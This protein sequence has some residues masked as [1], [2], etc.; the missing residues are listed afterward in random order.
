MSVQRECILIVLVAGIGDL[1]LASKGIRAIRNGYPEAEIHLLTS[2]DAAPLA[3][4]Y[5]YIDRV[6]PFPIRE[7]RGDRAHALAVLGLIRR[8]RRFRFRTAVNLY[9]VE[10]AAGAFRM[11]SLMMLS[12]AAER[13]GIDGY[14][15]GY[16]LTKKVSPSRIRGRHVADAMVE[17]ALSAGGVADDGGIE[18]FW[19]P[20]AEERC[21]DLLPAGMPVVG[22]N[23]GGLRCNRRWAPRKFAEVADRLIEQEGVIIGLLGGPGEEGIGETV[24]GDMRRSAVNLSGRL[25][26][27]ELTCV[28]SRLNALITNDSAPMHIAAAT[29]TP[30]VA[31]FGPEDHTLFRP[32]AEPGAYEIASADIGCRPCRKDECGNPLCLDLI[33]PDV[34]FEKCRRLLRA[35]A[36]TGEP[37][38]RAGTAEERSA[39]G[40]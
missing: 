40:V 20:A 11:G 19:S 30:Q 27:E 26:L 17:I 8:L 35:A 25:N 32:Y 3:R 7:L 16:F 14:G 28:I 37:R 2:T 29:G 38:G 31:L 34:V 1:V 21:R 15:L 6:W 36:R 4:H 9:S 23:P 24:L 33:T 39:I 5:P 22:I 18:V 13:V 12:G 10:S